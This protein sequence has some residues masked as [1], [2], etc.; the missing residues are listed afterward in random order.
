MN[1][2]QLIMKAFSDGNN[3]LVHLNTKSAD[4]F[5]DYVV[6]E[7]QWGVLANSRVYRMDEPKQDIAKIGI[8]E[9]IFYPAQRWQALSEDKRVQ[10]TAEKITL[11][12]EE[13]IWEVRIYD[14]ELEDNIE[15]NAFK[16]HLMRMIAKKANNQLE[17]VSL[18]SRKLANPDT[19]MQ[20]FDWFIKEV[21]AWGVVVDM[22]D[23]SN[24]ADRKISKEKL[25]KIRKAIPT[26]FRTMLNKWYMPEDLTIDYEVKYEATQNEVNRRG[27]FWI[28]FTK[29]NLMSIER[30]VAVSWGYTDTLWANATAWDT[31]ITVWDTSGATANDEITFNLWEDKEF[32]TSIASIT[33]ATTLVIAD[34]L[35]F[36]LASAEAT[37]NSITQ[38]STDW[39]DVILTPDYNFIF[40]IQR[41]I[42]IEPD[43]QPKLRATDFVISMRIDFKVENP[44]M[45]AIGKN[46][47]VA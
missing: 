37:E 26:K 32:T 20:T 15:W 21:E 28:P 34:A 8:N 25:A 7:S 13:I 36:D 2:E 33:D 4:K 5:I 40:G 1:K 22:S 31:T 43:R 44:E 10:A 9:N 41:D 16:D 46:F 14:D 3:S 38:V 11:S 29:A 47:L 35:P 18:Y 12:T 27:A 42:T 30:P 39:A 24:F 45:T 6:D 17:T 19:L 23:T